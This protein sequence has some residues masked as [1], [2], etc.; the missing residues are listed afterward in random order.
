MR[1]TSVALYAVSAAALVG[2]NSGAKFANKPRPATP[3]NLAV[4]IN[5]QRVSISPTSVGAG[6]VVFIVTNQADKSESLTIRPAG[7]SGGALANTGPINPRGTAQVIVDFRPGRYTVGTAK[8]GATDAALAR[9]SSI[10]PAALHIG[11]PR[12]SANN[13]L[14]QP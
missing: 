6:P 8:T 11:P 7:G 9:A 4:Y 14:L 13:A 1:K 5:N 10:T 12:P 3:I 2:C